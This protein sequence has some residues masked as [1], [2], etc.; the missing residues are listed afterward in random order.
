M[1]AR[2]LKTLTTLGVATLTCLMPVQAA[3]AGP[4][5]G[6]CSLKTLHGTYSGAIVGTSS[7][8]GPYAQQILSEYHG[9]GTAW[10]Q[11]TLMKETSGPTSYTTNSTYTLNSDC[12]GTLTGVRNTGERVHYVIVATPDGTRVNILRTDPGYVATGE[13]ILARTSSR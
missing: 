12:T 5:A 4:K 2:Y 6:G 8:S 11:G 13:A 3:A 10:T 9:D 7:S 1:N